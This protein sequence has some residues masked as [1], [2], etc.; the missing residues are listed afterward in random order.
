VEDHHV[1]RLGVQ[2]RQRV[3]LTSTNR[4]FGL[5]VLMHHARLGDRRHGAS[6]P[7]AGRP[8]GPSR[9]RQPTTDLRPN[10]KPRKSSLLHCSLKAGD[11]S[12]PPQRENS[13]ML[14]FAG[15]VALA[16]RP[17]PIP[18]R[19]RPSNSS[20]PMV[21]CLKTWESRSSPGLQRSASIPHTMS[22]YPN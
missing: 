11:P 9:V 13:P 12:G 14:I 10:A 18:S 19:T 3:E 7:A 1:D 22:K 21:L 17:N 4:S 2:A 6:A 15:L 20:A 16:R 8:C 5:I